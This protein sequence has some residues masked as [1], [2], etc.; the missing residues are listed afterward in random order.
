ML[1]VTTI[2]LS[3]IIVPLVNLSL[4]PNIILISLFLSFINFHIQFTNSS[5]II[6]GV[7]IKS[8]NC[9]I[10]SLSLF[11]SLL[12]ILVTTKFKINE[13]SPN[14]FIIT[15]MTLLIIIIIFFFTSN[16]LI[17]YVI[18]ELSLIPT[19]IL[20]IKWGNQPE[21]LQ[22]AIYFVI[23]TICASLPLLF[24][25]IKIY[26][27]LSHLSLYPNYPLPVISEEI[28]INIYYLVIILPFLVKLP[29]WGTHLWLPKAHVE[30]PIR[31]SIILA[32]ILLKLGGYG[33][34]IIISLLHKI[35][36]DYITILLIRSNIWG[37]IAVRWICLRSTDIKKLIAYSSIIHI[38]LLVAGVITKTIIGVTGRILIIIAHGI[39]SPGIFSLANVNY[40]KT[41]TRNILIHK[42][43]ASI[44]PN[45]ILIW[46]ILIS[47]N[48]AAPPSINLIS[49]III[50]IRVLKVSFILS[51]IL[52]IITFLGGAYNLYLYSAQQG[53]NQIIVSP[54]EKDM[55]INYLS[56]ITQRIPCFILIIIIQ[57]MV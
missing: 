49:E 56:L 57:I 11:I 22:S 18:F 42:N 27:D 39:R 38:N 54:R 35:G 7:I 24:I 55:S 21:R 26:N 34:I 32:G 50:S 10:V 4:I 5:F 33:L 44:Q 19:L 40:E 28:G 30:A 43:I 48:I 20:I 41:L 23:Y 31:G 6:I 36:G 51:I 45:I 47:A 53:N 3:M 46:F 1:I 2:I 9:S 15:V 16:L 8:L 14:N 25:I 29:T 12:I 17:L 52:L 13:I 37:A